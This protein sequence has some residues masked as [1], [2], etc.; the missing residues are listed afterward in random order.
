M[1]KIAKKIGMASATFGIAT[2]AT[3]GGGGVA[4]ADGPISSTNVLCGSSYVASNGQVAAS[5]CNK[6]SPYSPT[7]KVRLVA[8]CAWS[9]FDS[10]SDIKTISTTYTNA[11]FSTPSCWYGVAGYYLQQVN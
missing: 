9:P 6:K 1:R 7:V 10:Y 11:S 3:L 8:D 2:A 4:N 5:W